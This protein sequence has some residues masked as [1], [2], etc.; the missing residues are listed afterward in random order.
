MTILGKDMILSRPT[1]S[2]TATVFA[3]VRA[4]IRA[5]ANRRA[6][7][8]VADLPDELLS[9]IGLRRDDVHA[10]LQ[11]GWRNDPTYRLAVAA[12]R[13]RIDRF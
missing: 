12:R 11:T 10:A 7:L 3:A 6:A 1:G 13:R 5:I 4:M 9:D 2:A 8:R